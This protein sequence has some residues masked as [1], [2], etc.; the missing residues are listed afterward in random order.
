[1]AKCPD[2][3]AGNNGTSGNAQPGPLF[4]PYLTGEHAPRGD[5]TIRGGFPNLGEATTHSSLM[6]AVLEAVA[7]SLF[8]KL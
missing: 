3:E 5:T 1:M 6:R 2:A 7:F 8:I 4:L